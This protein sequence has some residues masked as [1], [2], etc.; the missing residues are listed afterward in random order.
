MHKTLSAT[1][2]QPR[3][4]RLVVMPSLYCVT[5]S[6][7]VADLVSPPPV[8]VTVTVAERG[9]AFAPAIMVKLRNCPGATMPD[10]STMLT[11]T[12]APLAETVSGAAKPSC[13]AVKS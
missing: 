7:I 10:E 3:R 5:E 11:P 13:A 9:R 4:A 6:G 12:G 2:D 1:L 8:A